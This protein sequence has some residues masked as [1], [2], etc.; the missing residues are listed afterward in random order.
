[1]SW[2]ELLRTALYKE[3]NFIDTAEDMWMRDAHGLVALL[4]KN[5]VNIATITEVHEMPIDPESVL[6]LEA[7]YK[8]VGD[9]S[10]RRKEL[11]FSGEHPEGMGYIEINLR[12]GLYDRFFSQKKLNDQGIT[13]TI[14]YDSVAGEAESHKKALEAI[15]QFYQ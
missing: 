7:S 11:K 3:N 10:W 15:T 13:C 12:R 1:M 4:R 8:K 5:G 2:K 14:L 9:V 6:I